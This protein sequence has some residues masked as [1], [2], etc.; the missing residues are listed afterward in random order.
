[1]CCKITN[2]CNVISLEPLYDFIFSLLNNRSKLLWTNP[3][4]GKSV[5]NKAYQKAVEQLTNFPSNNHHGIYIWGYYQN[6]LWNTVYIGKAEALKGNAGL[7]GRIEKE[8]DTER[9]FLFL[10]IYSRNQIIRFQPA[11]YPNNWRNYINNYYRAFKKRG[12]TFIFWQE[13]VCSASSG[14][15]LTDI[16]KALIQYVRP[17]ANIQG[18]SPVSLPLDIPAAQEIWKRFTQMIDD[19]RH[20]DYSNKFPFI[21]I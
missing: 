20:N 9:A 10:Q 17:T 6:G 2:N 18:T 8:L 19:N 14:P 13:V 3:W 4:P 15:K 16:E 21:V 11:A 7:K 5:V 12:S 1:M